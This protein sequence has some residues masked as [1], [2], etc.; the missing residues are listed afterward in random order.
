LANI[1]SSVRL[2]IERCVFEELPNA[3]S[4]QSFQKAE[5]MRGYTEYYK[6]RFG[7]YRVGI[8]VE[9]GAVIFQRVLHRKEIYRFFP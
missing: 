8:K 5:K 3:G 4:I 7:N 6:I 2:E 1:P 9:N